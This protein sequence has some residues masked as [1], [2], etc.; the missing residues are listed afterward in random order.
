MTDL[1]PVM[2]LVTI[3][4]IGVLVY[5]LSPVLMP[6][7]ASAVLAYVSD[8]I[9]CRLQRWRI[10][11][12]LAVIAVFA[13]FFFLLVGLLF[14]L[15]PQIQI[16][17][18][19]FA[20]KIP[21]YIDW[22]SKN[23]IP[24]FQP[25]FGEG[26]SL[27]PEAIKRA[28]VAH[29]LDVSNFLRATTG[30]VIRSGL[31]FVGF[32]V[33]LILIPVVTFYL[34]L[35]WHKLPS[36]ILGLLPQPSRHRVKMLARETDQVLGSFLRGQLL[37]MLFLSAFYSS[38]LMVFGLELALP[39]GILAGLISFVPYLGVIV[40][41]VLASAAAYL[42][43]QDPVM[44]LAVAAVFFLGQLLEGMVL[45]PRL[46]GDRIGLH[47]VAVIFAVMA[48]GQLFGFVGVLLAL[49]VAAVLKVWLRH[50]HEFLTE[51]QTKSHGSR[52]RRMRQRA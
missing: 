26:L 50:W 43:F 22:V 30:N 51:P 28:F 39:I 37:V 14:V 5:L 18:A 36:R 32:L 8:P 47:P 33:N 9:V 17:A 23:V 16:Q 45:T 31:E 42:Q 4:L 48:G 7:L 41:L 46:V 27:D 19:N 29:W 49:P 52:R 25:I 21:Q 20:V 11:R 10:P 15:V 35:D 40:G 1:R 2:W 3:G 13:I 38:G 44:L 24:Q 6:F 34:L 12:A